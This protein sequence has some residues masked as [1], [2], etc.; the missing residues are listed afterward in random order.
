MD[1]QT[2]LNELLEAFAEN[3]R[4]AALDRLDALTAWISRGG[5]PPHV[6]RE[7]DEVWRTSRP[8]ERK[9]P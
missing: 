4:E 5:F 9:M 3:D 2:A 8:I 1:P 6:Q 7:R